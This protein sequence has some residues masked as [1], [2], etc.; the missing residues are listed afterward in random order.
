MSWEGY[1][2]YDGVEIVN[3]ARAQVYADSLQGFRSVYDTEG[4][5][6]YLSNPT[7]VDPVTDLAPWYDPD[8]AASGRFYGFYPLNFTGTEDSSRAAETVESTGDGGTPGRLRHAT[9][10]VVMNGLLLGA[11]EEA[12]EYGMAWLRRALLGAACS[13]TLSTEQALGA[14][15]EYLSA[16]PTLL[17]ATAESPAE[18]H[19]RY[20][21]SLE[22]VTINTGPSITLKRTLLCD[23]AVWGAQ[24]TAVAGIPFEF[25]MERAVLQDGA[26][27]PGVSGTISGLTTYT[28]VNCGTNLYAPIYDPLCPAL[29]IPPPPASVPLSCYVV[30]SSWNRR[31]ATIPANLVP[32]WGQVVP[33][34]TVNA[35]AELRGVR[36]RFYENAD[37]DV[38]PNDSPCDFVGDFVISYM[39]INSTLIFDAALE[40]I[41][42]ITSA[43]HRRR[44]D[45]LV[46]GTDGTPFDWPSL[47]CGFGYLLTLDVAPGQT[48]PSLDLSLTSRAV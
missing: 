11:D 6:V 32:Y 13:A 20:E 23:G 19:K 33:K 41:V 17:S 40:E 10:T 18:L 8:I 12:V 46:F 16:S 7:Y 43:G 38:D 14:R 35:T 5:L 37:G 1:L 9:K 30:P 21:R 29:V 24:F 34:V 48:A 25:G 28:E 39:P 26:Y 4:L 44:A 31:V 3:I 36:I 15:L 42:I 45:S 27:V 47:T 22:R 2:T